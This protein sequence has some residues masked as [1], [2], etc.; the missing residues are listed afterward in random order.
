MTK[1]LK[2][3][4]V[5]DI[6]EC[7]EYLKSD[8]AEE[9]DK[10]IEKIES[11]YCGIIDNISSGL[12]AN[13][14]SS[15]N[16]DLKNIKMNITILKE[17][18]EVFVAMGCKNLFGN[19]NHPNVQINNSNSNSNVIDISISF[20]E[21]RKN[22]EN[23]TALPDSEVEEI[24]SKIEELEKIVQSKDRKTKKW[25]NAKGIIKWIAD[26]GVDVGIALLP[27]LLQIK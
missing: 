13:F 5:A 20:E 15:Y 17:K 11:K 12:I 1:E 27:L 14:D 24:L 18:M 19:G 23:M 3:I 9:A 22:I 4:V 10:F 2:E 6:S 26:K 16:L 21:A 25:E 8:S 7:E